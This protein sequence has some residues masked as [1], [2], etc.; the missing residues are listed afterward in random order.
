MYHFVMILI[1]RGD[2]VTVPG[3]STFARIL[4]L[5]YLSMNHVELYSCLKILYQ[6]SATMATQT[7]LC[8]VVKDMCTK[9]RTL[10]QVCLP[11][12]ISRFQ[13]CLL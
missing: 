6:K 2:K 5:Y 1:N 12:I 8:S 13:S 7:A 4:R 11:T 3:D 10:K 9:P